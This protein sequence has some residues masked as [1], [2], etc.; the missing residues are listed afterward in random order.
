MD[1]LTGTAN[2]GM[3][4]VYSFQIELFHQYC[5]AENMFLTVMINASQAKMFLE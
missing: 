2:T 3:T 1:V 4:G 5:L